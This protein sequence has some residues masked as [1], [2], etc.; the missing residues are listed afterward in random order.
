MQEWD[1]NELA[2]IGGEGELRIGSTRADG[3]QTNLVI[4]W[5]VVVDGALYVRSVNGTTAPWYRGT[6]A[7]HRGRIQVTGLTKDVEFVDV[8]ASD[9]IGAEVDAAYGAKY[10][11]S[12]SAVASITS[13]GAR[14]AT[15]R[16]VP[17]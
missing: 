15:I 4:I 9:A 1:S 2:L 8:D 3:S 13:A 16:V 17:V 10:G 14:A 11:R 5:S 7:T 12:S 6:R